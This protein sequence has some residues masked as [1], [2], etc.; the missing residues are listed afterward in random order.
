LIQQEKCLLRIL[1]FIGKYICKYDGEYLH[2]TSNE[3]DCI[4]I[5]NIKSPFNANDDDV[6]RIV[7]ETN[8]F[9]K[10]TIKSN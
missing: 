2:L 1:L 9:L 7:S 5:N 8:S 6:S 10:D 3:F 4:D